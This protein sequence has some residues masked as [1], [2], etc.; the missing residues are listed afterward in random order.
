[1]HYNFI[2]LALFKCLIHCFNA[3]CFSF[4]SYVVLFIMCLIQR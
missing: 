2:P 1:M 4:V 3:S